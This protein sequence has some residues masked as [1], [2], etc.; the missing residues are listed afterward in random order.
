[1]FLFGAEHSRA[2][3]LVAF[4]AAWRLEEQERSGG[5]GKMQIAAGGL[6][7][8]EPLERGVEM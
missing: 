1:M 6:E 4:L 7:A 3:A 8:V 2:S 5:R